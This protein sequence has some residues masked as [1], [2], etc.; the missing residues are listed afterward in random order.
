M[1]LI[2]VIIIGVIIWAYSSA[3]KS[4]REQVERRKK[5]EREDYV[6]R[7]FPNAYNEY[8][9]KQIPTPYP[10]YRGYTSMYV[11]RGDEKCSNEEW[12]VLEDRLLAQIRCKQEQEADKKW[13]NDQAAFASMARNKSME[14][15]P[16]FGY[17][18]YQ[19][20]FNSR[21]NTTLYFKVWQHFTFSACLEGDLDY[22]YQEVTKINTDNLVGQRKYGLVVDEKFTKQIVNFLTEISKGKTIMVLYNTNIKYWEKDATLKTYNDSLP[23]SSFIQLAYQSKKW[24]YCDLWSGDLNKTADEI[25]KGEPLDNVVI[26]DACTTNEELVQNCKH[27]FTQLKDKRPLLTYISFIKC[28]SRAEMIDIIE[29][30]KVEAEKKAA[31]EKAKEE[32]RKRREAEELAEKK[33]KEEERARLQASAKQVLTTNAQIWEHLYGNFHYTWLLYYYPTTCDFE[34]SESEW[35]DRYTVW[36]FKNDPEK[37]ISEEDHEATLDEVIPQIK[38]KLVDTFGAE[39]LQ[40]IMLICL[41]ASTKAKNQARYEEFSNRLCAETE[42]ENGYPYVNIVKDGLPRHLTGQS[43]PPVVEIDDRVKGKYVL[44]FDDVI[45]KGRTMLRYKDLL[46]RKGATVIGGFTIGKT[47]HERPT[48]TSFI[49]P[50]FIIEPAF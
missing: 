37:G 34:A 20:S 40:F 16:T 25:M 4:E 39:Y 14:L 44:L 21:N 47:K 38:D 48:H 33:R 32:E 36:D 27:V 22:T 7:N 45:T 6:K 13:E 10:N 11:R 46:E 12:R 42:M 19:I 9:G 29:K 2:V 15:M 31:E 5:R 28:Y 18:T 35:D 3:K 49:P 50:D 30:S 8:W 17:Y 41:P 1:W 26:L 24:C 23:S 43:V